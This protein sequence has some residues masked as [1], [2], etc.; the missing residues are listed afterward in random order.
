MKDCVHFGQNFL[1]LFIFSKKCRKWYGPSLQICKSIGSNAINETLICFHL[2]TLN[3]IFNI[4]SYR[5]YTMTTSD[6]Y[7]RDIGILLECPLT[8]A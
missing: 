4:Q 6:A 1:P 8:N 7:I 2:S 5:A 3:E